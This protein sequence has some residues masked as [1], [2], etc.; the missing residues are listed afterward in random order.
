MDPDQTALIKAGLDLCWSQFCLEA[1]QIFLT[2]QQDNVSL[3]QYMKTVVHVQM[4]F[5]FS[6]KSLEN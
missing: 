5:L 1:A 3:F 6:I 2:L 4:F